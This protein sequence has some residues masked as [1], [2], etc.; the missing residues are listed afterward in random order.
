MPRPE[1]S[2]RRALVAALLG[3]L[4]AS[5]CGGPGGPPLPT[6]VR[7]AD[8][9]CREVQKEAEE[10]R[11]VLTTPT[12]VDSLKRSA[13]LSRKEVNQLRDL[14]RPVERRDDVRSYLA[15]L[16]DRVRAIDTYATELQAGP[17]GAADSTGTGLEL[18]SDATKKAADLALSLGLQ[19]CR[20]GIDMSVG[21]AGGV[22]SGTSPLGETNGGINVPLS[23]PGDTGPAPTS[24]QPVEGKEFGTEDG[25]G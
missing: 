9:I 21:G 5:A 3:L 4:A 1:P 17:G 6:W 25:A 13:E 7:S 18:F 11:P 8:D 10:T 23:I 2:H 16:D 20:A 19:T 22:T 14:E 12:L 15:A 24:P